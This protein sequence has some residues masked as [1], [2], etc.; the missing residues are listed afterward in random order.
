MKRIFL[1]LIIL[2]MT[3]LS[4]A[5]VLAPKG[6]K[7]GKIKIGTGIITVDS[8]TQYSTGDIKFWKGAV[9]LSPNLPAGFK[10]GTVAVPSGLTATELGYSDGVTS[11]IQTQIN[12]KSNK[13]DTITGSTVVIMKGDSSALITAPNYVTKKALQAAIAGVG[14]SGIKGSDSTKFNTGSHKLEVFHGAMKYI[15]TPQDSISTVTLEALNF[16]NVS[17]GFVESPTGTW[18]TPWGGYAVAT[19]SLAGDG[20]IEAEVTSTAN[21]YAKIGLSLNNTLNA[22]RWDYTLYIYNNQYNASN[23]AQTDL[24]GGTTPT[25]GDKW[26]LKRT[27]TTITAE[28]YRSSTWTVMHSFTTTSSATLYLKIQNGSNTSSDRV[29]NPKGYNV[30]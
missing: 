7:V 15:F 19:K 29:V 6:I 14:G 3:I 10:I 11:A 13:A 17:S 25:V 26:R 1:L 2:S 8:I 5:Q 9:Q 22:S 16:T 4:N 12:T 24:Y 30:H 23:I 21:N 27:G 18:G 20:W 28:Y